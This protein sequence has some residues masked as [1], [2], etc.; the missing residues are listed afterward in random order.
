[1]GYSYFYQPYPF[2]DGFPA[3]K[4]IWNLKCPIDDSAVRSAHWPSE[5][6]GGALT[7]L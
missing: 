1:M 2:L 7:Q 5:V 3:Q 4:G 6:K